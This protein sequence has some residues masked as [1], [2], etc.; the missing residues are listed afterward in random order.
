MGGGGGIGDKAFNA[1]L[2]KTKNY[3]DGDVPYRGEPGGRAVSSDGTKERVY[4]E[5]GLP[6]RDRHYTDHDNPYQHPYV[7]HDHDWG[8]D[9]KGKWTMKKTGY[10]SPP[11]PLEPQKFFNANGL[12]DAIA[13][14]IA[15]YAG[16]LI[17]KWGIA[18]L[19]AAPTGGLS[20][21]GAA[22]TP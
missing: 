20:Y 2:A 5:D 11:G 13:W 15:G 16:Y 14:G 21:V 7:P 6:S 4:G 18:T 3:G 10:P 9:D 22:I 1:W 17:I 8:F 19:L 12:S